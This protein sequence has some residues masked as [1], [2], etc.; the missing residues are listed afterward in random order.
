YL[1]R[2]AEDVLDA[3]QRVLRHLADVPAETMLFDPPEPAILV[4]ADLRPSDVARL[5]ADRVLG[6]ITAEGGPTGHGAIL[7][8]SLGIPAV[9]GIGAAAMTIPDGQI[10][11][12]DGSAGHVW[13]APD[14]QTI[15]QLRKRRERWLAE[16]SELR[17]RAQG[18]AR[19][20]SGETIEVA[21]NINLPD[22][23]ETALL[24][25]AEGVGLFRTE[26]LYFERE[27]PPSEEE[28]LEIYQDAAR[29]LKGK[30][31]VIRTL[32]VGGDKPL[33]YLRQ[34]RETNPFLGQRGLRY[35]L[36][37]PGLF[38][39]QMRAI[40]RA[41]ADYPIRVM[42]PMVSRWEE[43]VMVDA[44]I[45]EICAELQAEGLAFDEDLQR[46]VMIETPSAVLIADH[47]ARLVDF[48]SIG[49]N[50]LAQYIMAADRD[51]A[52][53]ANLVNPYQPA[54][55]RAIR[56]TVEAGHANGIK[57]SLCGEMAGDLK[58]T[59]LLIGLGIDALSMTPTAI[60]IVKERI[61]RLELTEAKRIAAMALEMSSA[62]EI[63]AYLAE[64]ED[65]DVAKM[66][67]ES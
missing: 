67:S 64:I 61:R 24:N 26:F 18:T 25:G 38:R 40:L 42:F 37:H 49:T 2:R 32:D 39:P 60:P 30:P 12:L 46:G 16:R 47:L 3:G 54:V 19:L 5:P 27:A 59:A 11:G 41:A 4:A 35:C 55:L 8:R 14:P 31:L 33:P 66:E 63:E 48:F 22:E 43:L 50:D 51:N 10:V 13:L 9:T 53:V 17:K 21:A 44:L 29:R 65:T 20:R 45:D 1:A 28:Q 15:E 36:D 6:I 52:A 23:L 58:A 34:P 62:E 56:E 7:A 57:V